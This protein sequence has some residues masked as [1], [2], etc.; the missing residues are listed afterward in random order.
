MARSSKKVG[1]II[2]LI[3]EYINQQKN[4]TFN[5][6]QVSYAIGA[7]TPKQQRAV[8]LTL[9]EMAFDGELIETTPGRYKAPA[10]TNFAT[11]TFVRRS[12]GKNS[13]ITDDDNETASAVSAQRFVPQA[14][15]TTPRRTR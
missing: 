5:Y 9:A 3:K 14:L 12:N 2:P 10:R 6:R 13:V 11:G 1:G 8:A 15:S 7:S 4:N